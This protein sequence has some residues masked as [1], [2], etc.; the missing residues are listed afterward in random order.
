MDLR[1]LIN[2]LLKDFDEHG[3]IPVYIS[4]A[5]GEYDLQVEV[6]TRPRTIKNQYQTIAFPAEKRLLLSKREKE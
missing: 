4:L 3:N 1:D 5:D 6:T 2:L